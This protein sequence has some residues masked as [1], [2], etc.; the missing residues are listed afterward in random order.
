MMDAL[1]NCASEEQ[2]MDRCHRLG[3]TRKV[4]VTRY[5]AESSIEEK[6]LKLQASKGALNKGA[7]AKLSADEQRQARIAELTTLFEL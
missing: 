1:W 6:I 4:T 2:A 5:I 7:L 3:Q